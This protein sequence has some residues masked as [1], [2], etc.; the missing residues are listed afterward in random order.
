MDGTLIEK[1]PIAAKGALQTWGGNARIPARGFPGFHFG[2]LSGKYLDNA[3]AQLTAQ[4]R[5]SS[6]TQA[7]HLTPNCP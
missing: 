7:T 2:P 3:S 1:S 4:Q 6:A 5:S